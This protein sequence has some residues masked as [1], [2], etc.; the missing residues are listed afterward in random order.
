MWERVSSFCDD[1]EQWLLLGTFNLYWVFIF[2][3]VHEMLD[4][5]ECGYWNWEIITADL[6]QCVFATF[7]TN[8]KSMVMVHMQSVENTCTVVF[9][10]Q[11]M[12]KKKSWISKENGDRF[13]VGL[14][15]CEEC[16]LFASVFFILQTWVPLGYWRLADK[17]QPRWRQIIKWFLQYCSI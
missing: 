12:L 14:C 17:A 11:L 16:C 9:V 1:G 3:V 2:I 6:M 10:H 4:L 13:S 15:L 5:L 8:C 7:H